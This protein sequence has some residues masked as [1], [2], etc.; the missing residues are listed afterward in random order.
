MDAMDLAKVRSGIDVCDVGGN[1][2]G[3]VAHVYRHAVAPVADAEAPG[4]RAREEIVEVKTGPLGLGKHLYIPL[5]A[6]DTLNDAG[7]TLALNVSKDQ[8][9]RSWESKPDYLGEL[10]S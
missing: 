4:A 1:K 8:L 2:V 10:T 9:D 5:H 7:D 6:I 3:T